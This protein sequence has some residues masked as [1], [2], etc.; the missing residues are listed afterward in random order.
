MG[1]HTLSSI[2]EIIKA[3]LEEIREVYL[4]FFALKKS[5]YSHSN[6]AISYL[7]NIDIII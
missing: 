3:V 5:E 6:F 4:K 2:I 1:S 7:L